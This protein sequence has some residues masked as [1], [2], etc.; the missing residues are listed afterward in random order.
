MQSL[1]HA[2]LR[3]DS[4]LALAETIT[5]CE[6]DNCKSHGLYRLPHWIRGLHLGKAD[7][8]SE[9]HVNDLS[10]SAVD[11]DANL[12]FSPLALQRGLP[13]L[14]VKAHQTGIAILT[15]R[16]VFHYSA[17]WH[18][19]EMLANE[20]L[21]SMAFLTSKSFM[22][23]A[24]GSHRLYGTNP[25]GFGFPRP[26]GTPP[27]VIDQASSMMARGE[28]ALMLQKGQHLPDGCALGPDGCPT[29]DPAAALAGAQ[30]PFGLHK[31]SSIALMVEL[32]ASGMTG[33]PFSFQQREM[34]VDETSTSPTQT[35]ETVI[36][37]DPV[38]LGAA[39]DIA[40]LHDHVDLF[41]QQLSEHPN[42]RLPFSKRPA[43]RERSEKEGI[44]IP[45][46]LCDEILALLPPGGRDEY[47]KVSG[48]I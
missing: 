35:A 42:A 12:G 22:A 45:G 38:R 26:S 32:L 3:R 34:D 16:N 47:A 8:Q 33:S 43:A 17:L 10:P 48:N 5:A 18:E 21:V 6:R 27:V 30:L 31:G 25:M 2:G 14:A 24:G 4:S 44:E 9:P 41:I 1:L 29:S 7:G 36:A 20:G 40:D 39:R 15:V 28:I 19:C 11:V 13:V 46:H 23:P 37:I